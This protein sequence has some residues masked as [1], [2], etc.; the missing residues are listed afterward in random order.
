M[1]LFTFANGIW[2]K[3]GGFFLLLLRIYLR[4]GIKNRGHDASSLIVVRPTATGTKVVV[5]VNLPP[6]LAAPVFPWWRSWSLEAPGR[7]V[8]S[9]VSPI[10]ST[11][12]PSSG[13][14]GRRLVI[15]FCNPAIV[16]FTSR[17]NLQPSYTTWL[18]IYCCSPRTEMSL[19]P[20]N[21]MIYAPSSRIVA[22]TRI[23]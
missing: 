8:S 3:T 14:L 9:R 22:W 10:L 23:Y 12:R 13:F 17:G 4:G 15:T 16:F 19:N 1:R 11:E 2:P 7:R 6:K 18:K 21:R 5:M 20:D